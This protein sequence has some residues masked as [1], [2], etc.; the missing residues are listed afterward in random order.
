MWQ[1]HDGLCTH[2]KFAYTGYTYTTQSIN[3]SNDRGTTSEGLQVNNIVA[4]MWSVPSRQGLPWL[5]RS[6]ISLQV[7]PLLPWHD[8][9]SDTAFCRAGDG[10][11][12]GIRCWRC[13]RRRLCS[14][15][16]YKAV[17]GEALFVAFRVCV[18]AVTSREAFLAQMRPTSFERTKLNVK[19]VCHYPSCKQ[20]KHSLTVQVS[21]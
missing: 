18:R 2:T 7:A 3:N 11:L 10:E 6:T 21:R 9:K 17:P 1:I 4:K 12:E 14:G 5:C 16:R 20:R 8:S 13:D 15:I 19:V